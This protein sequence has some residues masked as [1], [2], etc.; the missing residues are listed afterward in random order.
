MEF[1]SKLDEYL[2]KKRMT[3]ADFVLLSGLGRTA[4]Y[5]YTRGG[6]SNI[7]NAYLIEKI[8]EGFVKATDLRGKQWGKK[9]KDGS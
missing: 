3:I 1:D 4:I 6:K 7:K 8:T 5:R 9:K 2:Y